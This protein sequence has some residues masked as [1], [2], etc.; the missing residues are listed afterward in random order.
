MRSATKIS[1]PNFFIGTADWNARITPIRNEISATI[2]S[3]SAPT[4][5]QISQTS[6]QRIDDGCR[7]AYA[8]AAT[9]SP[10]NVSCSRMSRS[11][12]AEM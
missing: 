12:P 1:A 7:M 2:G 8:S 3:A 11:M 5:S 4:F 9:A 6:R 10:T